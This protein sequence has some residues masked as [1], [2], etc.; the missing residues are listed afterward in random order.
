MNIK[1]LSSV[2]LASAMPLAAKSPGEY[3]AHEWGTFTSVQGSDGILLTWRPLVSSQLPRFVH[4]WQK[5]GLGRRPAGQLIDGK[6]GLVSLQRLETPV[7]YFYPDQ[8]MS[9]DVAVDF[10]QGAITE[11]YPQ[12]AQIGPSTAVTPPVVAEIDRAAHHLG[13][14]PDFTVASW[15]NH[16]AL[17]ASRIHWAKVRLL[18]GTTAPSASGLPYDTVGSHY[19]AARE[20]D[21]A[22]LQV[23]SLEATNPAPEHEKFLFYRGAGSFNTPV[24]VTTEPDETLT[25][26]N[27][28]PDLLQHLFVLRVEAGRS[29]FV[30]LGSLAPGAA[31]IL[32][33]GAFRSA[34]TVRQNA[35]ELGERMARSLVSEGLFAREA[36]AMVN[37]WKDS[38][39]A[40]DG[41]RVLY[42]LPR[43]WTDRIL[44]L[45]LK[46]A[47]RQLVRVMVGR[48]EVIT[49]SV[50]DRLAQ[51]LTKAT[52][53]NKAA[54]S[55]AR[56]ELQ[57]LGRFAEPAL[58]LATRDASPE[59][60]RAVWQIFQESTQ[61]AVLAQ[62]KLT[63]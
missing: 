38:W 2:L 24:R 56:S 4:D 26:A 40:E 15:V 37:T 57:R 17:N 51:G 1:L 48:A 46:P 35:Q 10:P 39:F 13:A 5:P 53:G 44:P 6:G 9:V 16:Q 50:Q 21:A 36:G 29:V 55:A 49:P 11:W 42:I 22:R 25:L 54:Q 45:V 8:P 33:A 41:L 32:P 31:R 60:R 62:G 27:T 18:S 58:Q 3:L 20:T 43:P 63:R 52:Q 28:G 12:A 19:F 61:P 47:P 34:S 59:L 23:D 7:I 30:E 14:A